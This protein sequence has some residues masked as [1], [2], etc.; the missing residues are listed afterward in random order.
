VAHPA[1][2][3]DGDAAPLKATPPDG[4]TAGVIAARALGRGAWIA[5]ANEPLRGPVALTPAISAAMRQALQD[6]AV[7]LI[8]Q[9]PGASSASTPTP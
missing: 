7:N 1:R 4:A 3:P 6:A 9:E 5:P 2:W 8:R